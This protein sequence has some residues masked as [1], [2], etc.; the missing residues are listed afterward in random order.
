M[1]VLTREISVRLPRAPKRAAAYA[2]R[3]AHGDHMAEKEREDLADVRQ[4]ADLQTRHD[5]AVQFIAF[6]NQHA[7]GIPLEE[8]DPGDYVEEHR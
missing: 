5:I 7:G 2:A 8:P 6:E 3:V 1:N 4:H